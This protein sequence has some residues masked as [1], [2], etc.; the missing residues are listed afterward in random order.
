MYGTWITHETWETFSIIFHL[1]LFG[2]R[3]T[4][5]VCDT[6]WKLSQL[7]LYC[8]CMSL[9]FNELIRNSSRLSE[10]A[11]VPL[12]SKKK[13]FTNFLFH[14]QK[15]DKKIIQVWSCWKYWKRFLY[16][17]S[18]IFPW[19]WFVTTTAVYSSTNTHTHWQTHASLSPFL[20]QEKSSF[21]NFQILISSPS[22]VHEW[23]NE[24]NLRM[25]ADGS[26]REHKRRFFM[27]TKKAYRMNGTTNE[28][29]STHV[30]VSL[31]SKLLSIPKNFRKKFRLKFSVAKISCWKRVRSACVFLFVVF[32]FAFHS[33]DVNF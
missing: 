9:D 26:E 20:C 8:V 21:S 10:A 4:Q 18:R 14:S 32:L 33:S 16:S 13:K 15:K 19:R 31:F 6:S 29:L 5:F 23:M 7:H 27:L 11:C 25:G 22:S 1:L 12:S 28:F 3:D 30:K 2:A 24:W 17:I